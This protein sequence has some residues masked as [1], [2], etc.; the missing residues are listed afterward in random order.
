MEFDAIKEVQKKKEPIKNRTTKKRYQRLDKKMVIQGKTEE[1]YIKVQ[2]G[3]KVSFMDIVTVKKYDI[4]LMD[5]NEFFRTTDAYWDFMKNYPHPI[6]E[7]Y[8][9]FDEDNQ[10]QQAYFNEKIKKSKNARQTELL[11]VELDKLQYIERTLRRN[12]VY[13]YVFAPTVQ[14]LEN[15]KETIRTKF[16]DTLLHDEIDFNT[17]TRIIA[18]VING[19]APRKDISDEIS[20]LEAIQP[21]GNI[22]FKDEF[23][24]RTGHSY[25]SCLHVYGY[26]SVYMDNWLKELTNHDELLPKQVDGNQTS[27]PS[28]LDT[29]ITVDYMSEKEVDYGEVLKGT[30]GEYTSQ[31]N[32]ATDTTTRDNLSE[33]V[34][35]AREL[36]FKVNNAGEQIKMCHIRIFASAATQVECEKHIDNIRRKLSNKGY[37]SEV[38]LE[39]NLEEWQ[40]LFLGYDLQKS[41]PSFHTGNEIPAEAMGLGFAHNQTFLKDPSGNYFGFTRTGGTVYW[42]LFHKSER[43]LAYNLFMAGDMGA[44]KSTAVKKI[45]KSNGI[46]GNF[47]RGFDKAGEFVQVVSDIGG[48]SIKLNGEDGKLNIFQVYPNITMKDAKGEYVVDE[49]NSFSQH[50]KNLGMVYQ[51]KNGLVD[52][53]DLDD[54]T[55]LAYEFYREFGLWGAGQLSITNLPESEY[56]ILEDWVAFLN[57]K[58]KAE[59]EPDTRKVYRKIH[60]SFLAM[61]QNY[62]NIFNGHTSI[63]D[64]SKQQILFYETGGLESFDDYVFDIQIYT[65]TTQIW[66]TM[67]TLGRQEQNAYTAREKH[68]FDYTRFLVVMDECH[69]YLN[70]EKAYTAKFFVTMLSEARKFFA[71][72]VFATQ[73]LE[74]MFPKADNVQ[75]KEMVLAA[76]QL[77]QIVGLC[78]YKMIFKT[79]EASMERLKSVFG[80][81]LTKSEYDLIPRFETGDCI[82]SMSGDQNLTMHVEITQE[83]DLQFAGGA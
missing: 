51:L 76:N 29:I 65:A 57:R 70:I 75:A 37:Q 18:T 14:E 2:Y 9:N 63:P 42:D 80:N 38:Y 23:H 59:Q 32:S 64:F 60:K 17:K 12:D 28:R 61:L 50:V 10:L 36:A 16:S 30:V 47:I 13:M 41:L 77:S 82:L 25:Q 39:E 4:E 72:V 27:L 54:I 6:K 11:E 7:V 40:S 71:G 31:Y 69:N 44:G 67:T 34:L 55:T 24:V 83:E 21:Q 62:G 5:E 46:K 43:R 49:A 79:D 22:S 68:W 3:A 74:R 35:A 66:S 33:E 73:R 78:P 15:R 8:L 19:E 56:P 52:A 1:G 45:V 58:T 48:H 20:F 81:Q 26:P 53:G